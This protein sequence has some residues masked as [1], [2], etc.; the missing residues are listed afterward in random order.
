MLSFLIG[1]LSVVF[2][3]LGDSWNNFLF[4][5]FSL[6]GETVRYSE[7]LEL[8][9]MKITVWRYD[10]AFTE[11]NKLVLESCTRLCLQEKTSQQKE[12]SGFN[13]LFTA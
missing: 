7:C 13:W 8:A 6:G 12:S 2:F 3:S 1:S 5:I 9:A 11:C 4:L 10:P